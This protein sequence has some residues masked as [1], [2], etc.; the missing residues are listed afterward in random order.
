[1]SDDAGDKGHGG[2]PQPPIAQA[3]TAAQTTATDD[4]TPQPSAARDL[5]EQQQLLRAMDRMMADQLRMIQQHHEFM[6]SMLELRR[7]SPPLHVPDGH[8]TGQN[9]P[10]AHVTSGRETPDPGDT[11]FPAAAT[12][13]APP[14]PAHRVGANANH[15]G[16]AIL[17]DFDAFDYSGFLDHHMASHGAGAPR[18]YSY[19]G[20][21]AQLS[22]LV[23]GVQEYVIHPDRENKNVHPHRPTGI[24]LRPKTLTHDHEVIR[25]LLRSLAE[26]SSVTP[27]C[28]VAINSSHFSRTDSAVA[29]TRTLLEAIARDT[30]TSSRAALLHSKSMT[31]DFIQLYISSAALQNINNPVLLGRVLLE[32]LLG[33]QDLREVAE[34]LTGRYGVRSDSTFNPQSVAAY[35]N[36][37]DLWEDSHDSTTRS[38]AVS[39][40]TEVRIRDYERLKQRAGQSSRVFA[41]SKMQ[42]LLELVQDAYSGA[43]PH[44]AQLAVHSK[45]ISLTR[46]LGLSSVMRASF[47]AL[48][49]ADQA[50]PQPTIGNAPNDVYG[51]MEA[52]SKCLHAARIALTALAQRDDDDAERHALLGRAEHAAPQQQQQQRRRFPQQQQQQPQQQQQLPQQQQQRRQQPQ[53]QHGQPRNDGRQAST[54]PASAGRTATDGV[55]SGTD[56]AAPCQRRWCSRNLPPHNNG[57]R[58]DCG[59]WCKA[60]QRGTTCPNDGVM[61]DDHATGMHFFRP[62]CPRTLPGGVMDPTRR[63]PPNNGSG[64]GGGGSGGGGN[65]QFAR[66]SGSTSSP[67]SSHGGGSKSSG[68]QHQAAGGKSADGK[69]NTRSHVGPALPVTAAQTNRHQDPDSSR[70]WDPG[71][72]TATNAVHATPTT[73][74]RFMPDQHVVLVRFDVRHSNDHSKYTTLYLHPDSAAGTVVLRPDALERVRSHLNPLGLDGLITAAPTGPD[75]E[76]FSGEWVT[77]TGTIHFTAASSPYGIYRGDG[78]LPERW[79]EHAGIALTKTSTDSLGLTTQDVLALPNGSR[80]LRD[81]ETDTYLNATSSAA[82]YATANAEFERAVQDGT[83]NEAELERLLKDL[84]DEPHPH[85]WDLMQALEDLLVVYRA[86]RDVTDTESS[87]LKHYQ[88]K[89]LRFKRLSHLTDAAKADRAQS[90]S[91]VDGMRADLEETSGYPPPYNPTPFL[92]EHAHHVRLVAPDARA[93]PSRRPSQRPPMQ[94]H[95]NEWHR[96][97]VKRKIIRRATPDEINRYTPVHHIPI[98]KR[99]AKQPL[100]PTSYRWAVDS[101]KVNDVIETPVDFTLPSLLD[102]RDFCDGRSIFSTLDVAQFFPSIPSF[103]D[104]HLHECEGEWYVYNVVVQGSKTASA[105]AHHVM[106]SLLGDLIRSGDVLVYV[107]DL[108]IA[109][110]TSVRHRHVLRTVLYRLRD[111]GLKVN[112]GKCNFHSPTCTFLGN[113]ISAHGVEPDIR[114][115]S[116]ILLYPRPTTRARANRFCAFINYFA[117]FI[118]N[119]ASKLAPL[120]ELASGTGPFQWTPN[121]QKAFDD[122]RADL[123]NATYL[124]PIRYQDTVHCHVDTSSENGI[125]AVLYQQG[126]DD[127]VFYPIAYKSRRL[128]PAERGKGPTD[129]E[130]IGVHWAITAAFA[131]ILAAAPIVVHSD[132][133]NLKA[134]LTPSTAT[135]PRR[136]RI[137]QQL[138]DYNIT[139]IVYER[140]ADFHGPDITSRL[141]FSQTL[142]AHLPPS[143]STAADP[144]SPGSRPLTVTGDCTPPVWPYVHAVTTRA[145]TAS[146]RTTHNDAAGTTYTTRTRA[147]SARPA[148][149]DATGAPSTTADSTQRPASATASEAS[150]ATVTTPITY[151]EVRQHQERDPL[152]QAVRRTLE[153]P[154]HGR[155]VPRATA[156]ISTR[157]SL[158]HGVIFYRDIIQRRDE[159]RYVILSPESLIDR[160]IGAYHDHPTG[161]RGAF[162]TALNIRSQWWFPGMMPRVKAA[163]GACDVCIRARA[164]SQPLPHG[165]LSTTQP[166]RPFQTMAVDLYHVKDLQIP[167]PGPFLYCLVGVYSMSRWPTVI[168]LASPSSADVADALATCWADH[169]LPSLLYHDPGVEFSGHVE[170]VCASLGVTPVRSA[171]RTHESVGAVE[172]V[173]RELKA[174]LKRHRATS[175]DIPWH[176]FIPAILVKLRSTPSASTG[177]T[178]YEL[179]GVTSPAPVGA[180]LDSGDPIFDFDAQVPDLRRLIDFLSVTHARRT[181]AF[182][183]DLEARDDRLVTMNAGRRPAAFNVGDWV[184][185]AIPATHKTSPTVSTPRRVAAVIDARHYSVE[186]P[187]TGIITDA[188][189]SS[190]R[191]A[192][193]PDLQQRRGARVARSAAA[194][195]AALVCTDTGDHAIVK[196]ERDHDDDD[197]VP[198]TLRR[199]YV[200]AWPG[201]NNDAP[202]ASHNWTLRRVYVN[203]V[204][205]L[206][207]FHF[208]RSSRGTLTI[209]LDVRKKFPDVKPRLW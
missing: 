199:V 61:V 6:R 83:L 130:L 30:I 36:V 154:D 63:G 55:L 139:D 25:A 196:P 151:A 165:T 64:K 65:I 176:R 99:G 110:S 194:P 144:S 53:H 160:I 137:C 95:F 79:F 96:E 59:A 202:A 80:L 127:D 197:G 185:V 179:A 166:V 155:R 84:D 152:C 8:A 9:A 7:P 98:L 107:D 195:E 101:S 159:N 208:V 115:Y 204:T 181:S 121:H 161:H 183:N 16:P 106:E 105:A 187:T 190:L 71:G 23:D 180:T 129:A 109:S 56:R 27:A 47:A 69:S 21:H 116:S 76:F 174:E 81:L 118:S 205:E 97:M 103:D 67:T 75:V 10:N 28:H 72:S 203:P 119:T 175:P 128:T 37:V 120:R 124:R 114:R 5:T 122:L 68:R 198:A 146:T 48:F 19:V 164:S 26:G 2:D 131:D 125:G 188:G 134:H 3:S 104:C 46:D 171:P 29:R 70:V 60:K 141:D 132:H 85:T 206:T 51:N 162:N 73:T 58:T 153:N 49:R 92:L 52:T 41:Q 33:R 88:Q 74:P 34:S 157:C 150:T 189:I 192:D 13:A 140:G 184:H 82:D 149:N 172:R 209:P 42:C 170:L 100:T 191:P 22:A 201:K 90:I 12:P 138:L 158:A 186:D 113:F 54:L 135:S 91:I 1:M 32:S 89:L 11:H 207:R 87:L 24:S 193:A 123:V 45:A 147:A 112:A 108:L 169:G 177:F 15:G 200:N 17:S 102:V 77:T 43:L 38:A 117:P 78:L 86:E 163:I 136:R 35:P 62:T 93:Q 57:G 50:L 142:P 182:H 31:P 148:R 168:P 173:N 145:R 14:T 18:R 167:S 66:P 143:A 4:P 94:A 156:H 178:P 44:S 39:T 20:D 133:S 126:V 40:V 111:A